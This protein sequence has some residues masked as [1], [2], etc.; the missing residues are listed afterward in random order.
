MNKGFI[1][2]IA[3][4]VWLVLAPALTQI[5]PGFSFDSHYK[6]GEAKLQFL[7]GEVSNEQASR[8]PQQFLFALT[9]ARL[10]LH[11]QV[12]RL[13]SFLTGRDC[14]SYLLD[15]NVKG[16]RSPPANLV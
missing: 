13:A 8:A 9:P 11:T 12:L 7:V 5:D 15:R 10:K 4:I 6:H 1:G 14:N 2:A 3:A 16:P